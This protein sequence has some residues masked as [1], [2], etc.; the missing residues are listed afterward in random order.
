MSHWASGPMTNT[1]MPMPENAMP[2]IRPRRSANQRET[3]TPVGTH[4]T[5]TIPM[6]PTTPV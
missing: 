6:A 2:I 1:P 3:S 5:D 4:P